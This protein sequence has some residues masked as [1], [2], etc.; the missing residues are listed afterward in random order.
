MVKISIGRG[1]EF[2]CTNADIV[3]SFIVNTECFVRVFNKLL[4]VK[5]HSQGT[6]MDGESS[7]IRFND[8][9]RNLG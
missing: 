8:S 7:V 2:E 9:I 3:Q 6:Y 1:I 5:K 4:H